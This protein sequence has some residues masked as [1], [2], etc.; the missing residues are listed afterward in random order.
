LFD[1]FVNEYPDYKKWL[2]QKRFKQWID[3]F[4]KHHKANIFESKD[5]EG[6][7]VELNSQTSPTDPNPFQTEIYEPF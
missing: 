6:R 7:F 1:E 5:L 3:T 4:G 2:S